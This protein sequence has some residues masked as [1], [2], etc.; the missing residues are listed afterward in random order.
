MV[1]RLFIAIDL[2]GNVRHALA[3]LVSAAPRGSRAVPC[4][5]LHLTLHFLG[6]VEDEAR[7]LMTASLRQLRHE[8]FSLTIAGLGVF[9]S[10][11]HPTVLWAGIA[12][13][14]PLS[15]LHAAIGHA[16]EAC[17]RSI[18]HRGYVPHVTLARLAGGV[19]RAW[20]ADVLHRG[21]DVLH[22]DVPV[23]RFHLYAS[24]R[25]EGFT[26]H[27]IVTTFSLGVGDPSLTD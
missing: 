15:A 7:E 1:Q 13:S 25:R 10:R 21:D 8:P 22:P 14:A 23:D 5:Q 11:G 26:E 18:E 9:P 3:R 4:G 19:S 6:D 16:L 2:P 12:P 24:L 20:L 27:S 17:G